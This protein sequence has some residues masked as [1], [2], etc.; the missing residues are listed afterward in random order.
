MIETSTGTDNAVFSVHAASNM[1]P[2]YAEINIFENSEEMKENKIKN[3]NIFIDI[4][5]IATLRES[6]CRKEYLQ[7]TLISRDELI[8]IV[9]KSLPL[10]TTGKVFYA[11]IFTRRVRSNTSLVD[12]P[13]QS[14][15]CSLPLFSLYNCLT[16][17]IAHLHW[18]FACLWLYQH[19]SLVLHLKSDVHICS[20]SCW[21][22]DMG[23]ALKILPR[24]RGCAIQVIVTLSAHW[25]QIRMTGFWLHLII[26]RQPSL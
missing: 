19:I 23:P 4:E 3:K 15:S 17:H 16:A 2:W 10:P 14:P 11:F 12:S 6:F 18:L 25:F 5:I 26:M 8:I 22:S 20:A 24:L 13:H 7:Q 1:V 9:T 21:A